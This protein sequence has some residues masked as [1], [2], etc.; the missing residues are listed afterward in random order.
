MEK[1]TFYLLNNKFP[2]TTPYKRASATNWS[3]R[4]RPEVWEECRLSNRNHTTWLPCALMSS[5]PARAAVVHCAHAR[6]GEPLAAGWCTPVRWMAVL[7]GGCTTAARIESLMT[8][9]VRVTAGSSLGSFR[10]GSAVSR[11]CRLPRVTLPSL[12][13]CKATRSLW[14][15]WKEKLSQVLI[16]WRRGN[17]RGG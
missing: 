13:H 2:I 6:R 15:S 5:A 10:I 8:R 14:T 16:V 3:D 7:T 12:L 9:R 4:Q 11:C 1:D 17:G